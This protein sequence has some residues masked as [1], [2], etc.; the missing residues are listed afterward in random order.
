MASAALRSLA[1]SLSLALTAILMGGIAAYI[2]W[3]CT[4]RSGSNL[5]KWGP[6]I[7]TVVAAMLILVDQVR[8]VV[9]DHWDIPALYKWRIVPSNSHFDPNVFNNDYNCNPEMLSFFK[10]LAYNYYCLNLTGGI[11]MAITYLGFALLIVGTMW[12]ANLM[13][14]LK[15]VRDTWREL[16]SHP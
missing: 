8:A 6:L 4:K 13:D 10:E 3:R 2:G 15:D 16:R 12:N 7:V 14:K 11:C 1:H 5:N 9:V